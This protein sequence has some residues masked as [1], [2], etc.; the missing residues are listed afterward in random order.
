MIPL[1]RSIAELMVTTKPKEKKSERIWM[2]QIHSLGIESGQRKRYI[3]S[4]R[5]EGVRLPNLKKVNGTKWIERTDAI[6][7]LVNK[8]NSSYDIKL[9]K[10]K[11]EESRKEAA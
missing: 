4:K 2:N 6:N 11:R 5:E 7:K 3:S 8:I 10:Q 9:L 1:I